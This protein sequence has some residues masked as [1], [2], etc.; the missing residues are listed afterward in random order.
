MSKAGHAIVVRPVIISFPFAKL[1]TVIYV[2][3]PKIYAIRH[4]QLAFVKIMFMDLLATSAKM[5]HS[6]CKLRIQKDAR[7]ASVL[8]RHPGVSLQTCLPKT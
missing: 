5:A 2:V 8:E 4:L 6:I 1:V 7:N 3:P